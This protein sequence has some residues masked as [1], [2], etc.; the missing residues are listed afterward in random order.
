MSGLQIHLCFPFFFSYFLLQLLFEIVPQEAKSREMVY[1]S[2]L[3]HDQVLDL[4]LHL[5]SL[6]YLCL[7]FLWEV[8]KSFAQVKAN[9]FF[10]VVYFYS[11]VTLN[12]KIL[13]HRMSATTAP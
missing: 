2:D 13:V 5:V 3:R 10:K 8:E 4:D 1:Q 12:V 7:K 6:P 9:D 11:R